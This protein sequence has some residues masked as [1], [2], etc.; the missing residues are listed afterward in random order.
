MSA[1]LFDYM[2]RTQRLIRDTRQAEVDPGDLIDYINDAR[3]EVAMRSQAIRRLP[4]ISG[5]IAS[6]QIVQAGSGYSNPSL[7]ISA[8]DSPSGALPYPAGA[9]ATGTVTQYLGTLSSA[10]IAFGGSG[11]FQ[12]VVTVTDPTGSGAVLAPVMTPMNLAMPSQEV[13]PFANVDLTPFPGVASVYTVRSVA[14]LFTQYRYTLAIYDFSTYQAKLRQYSGGA[15]LYTPCWG[16]QF[17]RGV[18]GSFYIY[19][20]PSQ[21]YQME[22]DCSCLPQDLIDNQSVECLPD[23]WTDAVPYWAARQAFLEM[24]NPNAARGMTDMFDDRMHRFGA[25]VDKGRMINPYGRP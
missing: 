10:G 5:S 1:V 25:Y 17:G 7:V 13:Y 21:P 19:P 11:Y 16:A 24:Q 22:W 8:P 6:V 23:P 20:P 12:P 3:R 9:Q 4:L 14:I 15:Y 18:D 2:K